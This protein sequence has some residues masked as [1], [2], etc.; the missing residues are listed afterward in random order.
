MGFFQ[1][2]EKALSARAIPSLTHQYRMN[3]AICRY[4]STQFYENTLQTPP[5]V[6]NARV[7]VDSCGMW[8]VD[9]TTGLHGDHEEAPKGKNATSKM[10]PTEVEVVVQIVQSLGGWLL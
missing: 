6:A 1:R 2:V 10:N 3:P 8:W 4:I 5:E 9:Y 7:A